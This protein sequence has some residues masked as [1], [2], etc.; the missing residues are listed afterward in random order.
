[1]ETKLAR[2]EVVSVLHSLLDELCTV[3]QHALQLMQLPASPLIP[4]ASPPSPSSDVLTL[5]ASHLVFLASMAHNLALLS[6]SLNLDSHCLYFAH[7]ALS[8][9]SRLPSPN[10]TLPVRTL[11]LLLLTA[12]CELAHRARP[13]GQGLHGET[14]VREAVHLRDADASQPTAMAGREDLMPA[15]LELQGR[16]YTLSGMTRYLSRQ[17]AVGKDVSEETLD[18]ELRVKAALET[19]RW[20]E[21]HCELLLDTALQLR[22]R[23]VARLVLTHLMQRFPSVAAQRQQLWCSVT[24]DAELFAYCTGLMTGGVQGVGFAAMRFMTEDCWTR[25]VLAV[26]RGQWEDGERMLRLGLQLLQR[27]T[28]CTDRPEA[29]DGDE[30]AVGMMEEQLAFVRQRRAAMQ[31]RA[32]EEKKKEQQPKA[33]KKQKRR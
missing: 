17:E 23:S 16:L 1:M 7:Y 21:K 24:E 20:S 2:G 5:P 18:V 15:V 32:E 27:S 26:R 22:L 30:V 13:V 25:G 8:M 9:S 11:R 33:H 4:T 28:D 10:P 19:G 12:L 3:Y 14:I 29:Q 31:L 6:S